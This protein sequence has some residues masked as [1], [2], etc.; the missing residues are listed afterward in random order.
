[1]FTSA[2]MLDILATF[3]FR[4]KYALKRSYSLEI[5]GTF[6]KARNSIQWCR[7]IFLYG[8][9]V[10]NICLYPGGRVD[11]PI[12]ILPLPTVATPPQYICLK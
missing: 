1:M 5:K 7:N 4:L 9:G 8:E 6:I 10:R 3:T 12:A 2:G 11:V